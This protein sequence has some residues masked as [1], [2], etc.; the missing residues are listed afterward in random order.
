M[1]WAVADGLATIQDRRVGV[2]LEFVRGFGEIQRNIWATV[3]WQQPATR[4]PGKGKLCLWL[5][6]CLGLDSSE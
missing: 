3:T 6:A 4:N 2:V 5:A 1:P